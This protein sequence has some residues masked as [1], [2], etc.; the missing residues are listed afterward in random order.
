MT[1]SGVEDVG[2]YDRDLKPENFYNYESLPDS[3]EEF[4]EY[5]SLDE[6]HQQT[7]FDSLKM[8]YMAAKS[9]WGCLMWENDL[10]FM[11]LDINP[12]IPVDYRGN[13]VIITP[14]QHDGEIYQSTENRLAFSKKKQSEEVPV[15]QE[16]NSGMYLGEPNIREMDDIDWM[17][18]E[19][20]I[21]PSDITDMREEEAENDVDGVIHR[22]GF[23]EMEKAG[24]MRAAQ[25]GLVN[26]MPEPL[27]RDWCRHTGSIDQIVVSER[28][29]RMGDFL[30]NQAEKTDSNTIRAYVGA[31]HTTGI[32][33]TL[34]EHENDNVPEI[35]F[36]HGARFDLKQPAKKL[37]CYL[38][39]RKME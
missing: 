39:K 4:F 5:D 38:E 33:S 9:T 24:Q 29:I 14:I 8:S 30:A 10:D 35:D 25:Y 20:Q 26:Y 1:E 16:Q 21:D 3:I 37:A 15:Y 19:H 13:E 2:F 17:Y 7:E 32:M 6:L 27:E 36:R 12:E 11:D 23:E 34:R 22:A 18:E 31:S 28:S